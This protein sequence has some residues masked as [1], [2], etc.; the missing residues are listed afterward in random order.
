MKFSRL[1]KRR[2][3][4]AMRSSITSKGQ[5][6]IPKAVRDYLGLRSGD[7]VKFFLHPDGSF[8]LLPELPAKAARGIVKRRGRTVTLAEMQAA[9]AAGGRG[10]AR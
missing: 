3:E 4:A 6:T 5:A 7:R 8:A 9:I 10:K 2:P 1:P